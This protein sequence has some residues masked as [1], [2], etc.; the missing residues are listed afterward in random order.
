MSGKPS[1]SPL[2]TKDELIEGSKLEMSAQDQSA[3]HNA[4]M[5]TLNKLKG[6]KKAEE[7]APFMS[8]P[9]PFV[10]P[11]STQPASQ[12]SGISSTKLTDSTQ[13]KSD[14]VKHTLDMIA[15]SKNN[16]AG[17]NSFPSILLPSPTPQAAPVVNQPITKA[18]MP[19]KSENKDDADEDDVVV[20]PEKKLSQKEEEEAE[21]D[22]MNDVEARQ[23]KL[24]E[25]HQKAKKKEE[26]GSDSDDEKKPSSQATPAPAP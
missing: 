26:D 11:P 15:A 4:V 6:I 24:V 19:K 9:S 14:A 22:Y 7:P 23:R 12:F 5:A 2:V 21:F 17:S 13:A 10:M 18:Q 20:K 1:V 16:N 25:K 8:T 3:S